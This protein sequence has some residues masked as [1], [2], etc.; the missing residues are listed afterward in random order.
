VDVRQ[1][2]GK[3]SYSLAQE[4]FLTEK[5]KK[6]LTS[7]VSTQVVLLAKLVELPGKTVTQQI[8]SLDA[9]YN[10]WEENFRLQFSDGRT[11][12]LKAQPELESIIHNPGP[13]ILAPFD[14][15]KDAAS[16]RVDVIQT[17][18]PLEAE[19]L[20]AVKKWMVGQKVTGSS[21]KDHSSR[22]ISPSSAFSELFYSL[23]KQA[24]AGEVLV[25]EIRRELRSPPFSKSSLKA[26]KEKI[27]P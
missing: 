10:L 1:Q 25:G 22:G 3:I 16:Y 24:S 7:G 12:E 17:V 8:V 14:E 9:K 18:N 27:I 13:F 5:N 26:S 4:P 11:K 6:D 20:E 19:R 2:D 21:P 23:W 15:L